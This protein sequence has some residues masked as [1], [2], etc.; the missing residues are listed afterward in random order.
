MEAIIV[1][2]I[3]VFLILLGVEA[4]FSKKYNKNFFNPKDTMGNLGTGIINQMVEVFSKAMMIALYIYVYDRFGVGKEL[5]SDQFVTLHGF[6][7]WVIVFVLTDIIYYFFHRHSHEVN[8]LWAAHMV[9]HS[10]E[11]YNYS[12]AL[13]QA[14]ISSVFNWA[15]ALILALIG[16]PSHMFFICY[17]LNL[18]YQF[19]IHTR[20]VGKL[21]VAE[22]I[23][24]TPSHHRVHHARQGKYLDSNYAGIFIF[25]DKLFGTF[26]EEEEEPKYGVYP[27]FQSYDPVR[28]NIMP[29]AEL[30]HYAR[31]A[32]GIDRFRVFFSGPLWLYEKYKK[33]QKLN[34]LESKKDLD[35]ASITIFLVAL[36]FALA[37]LFIPTLSLT[38][39]SGIIILVFVLLRAMGTRLDRA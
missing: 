23:L 13:R 26:T 38:S 36:V 25:W 3:P 22:K 8:F 7:S 17:G 12:V 10:S 18:L 29:Y 15:Y 34:I 14:G 19:W 30:F 21:G 32:R 35:S 16:I 11:E 37:V 33:G 20:F 31:K 27:R 28:A 6:F 4:F 24:N 39:K 9:H 5:W 1:I 2:S